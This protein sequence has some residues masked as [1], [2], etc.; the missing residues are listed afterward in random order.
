MAISPA[1]SSG[2]TKAN[3]EIKYAQKLLEKL[4]SVRHWNLLTLTRSPGWGYLAH[5]HDLHKF[6]LLQGE[7][8][9]NMIIFVIIHC[10]SLYWSLIFSFNSTSLT[11]WTSA[12]TQS[13]T[14]IHASAEWLI[15]HCLTHS[16]EYWFSHKVFWTGSVTFRSLRVN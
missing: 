14:H 3:V 9:Q 16:D 11:F 4:I 13:H 12:T 6:L 10:T 15:A 8:S 7:T 5:S 2:I 1:F